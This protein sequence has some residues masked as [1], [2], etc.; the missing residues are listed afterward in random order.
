VWTRNDLAVAAGH[1]VDL[2]RWQREFGELMTRIGSRFARVEPRRRVAA[3]L[4]GLLAGLPRA[5]CWSIAEQAAELGPQGTQRLLSRAVWDTDGVR[6]D[7]RDYVVEHLGHPDAVLV[8][9][10]C[11]PCDYA[12]GRHYRGA[13]VTDP[14]TVHAPFR[15]L[16]GVSLRAG[17]RRVVTSR[18]LRIVALLALGTST[19]AGWPTGSGGGQ[20]R[21]VRSAACAPS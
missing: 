12:E 7:L 4:Q 16:A 10:R 15:M 6:D 3:F 13:V 9:D 20:Q 2:D 18:A 5:N 17:P 21:G 11:R 1:S 19:A 14:A 8:I